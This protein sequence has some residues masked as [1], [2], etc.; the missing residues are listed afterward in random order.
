[1]MKLWG[2]ISI[3]I[4]LSIGFYDVIKIIKYVTSKFLSY[5]N[6]AQKVSRFD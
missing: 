2:F 5:I 4:T 1:M 3:A 6:K